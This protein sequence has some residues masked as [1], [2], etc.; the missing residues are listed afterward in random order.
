M[1]SNC[2]S[3]N[4]IFFSRRHL[5][6]IITGGARGADTLGEQYAVLRKI[7]SI[8]IPAKWDTN[9]KL[10]GYQRNEEMLKQ[11]DALIAFWDGCSHGTAH[12]IRISKEKKIQVRVIYF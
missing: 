9:G 7:H 6:C 11:A 4:A 3:T 5:T 1:I 8:V 2:W 10:A 12:M